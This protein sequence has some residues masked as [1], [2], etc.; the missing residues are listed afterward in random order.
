[1]LSH[2]NIIK[3]YKYGCTNCGHNKLILKNKKSE[4]KNKINI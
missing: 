2:H 3:F 1:M 4:Y